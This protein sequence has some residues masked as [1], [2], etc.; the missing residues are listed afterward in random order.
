[1]KNLKVL[2]ITLS[3]ALMASMLG[4]CQKE[5]EIAVTREAP[6][7]AAESTTE[8]TTETTVASSAEESTK[9]SS[10]ESTS[11][12]S[13]TAPVKP[14]YK[15]MTNQ[16][17]DAEGNVRW[18]IEKEYDDHGNEIRNTSYDEKGKVDSV[19]EF[20]YDDKGNMVKEAYFDKDGKVT[21]YAEYVYEFDDKGHV[22][23]KNCAD[24]K[25]VVTE[26]TEYKY[27]EAGNEIQMM[28]FDG[29]GKFSWGTKSKYDSDRR[30]IEVTKHA[31][32]NSILSRTTYEYDAQGNPTK[33]TVYTPTGDIEW[34]SETEYSAAGKQA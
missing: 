25:A 5:E 31:D 21:A 18:T 9:T 10:E 11:E 19:A 14:A 34:W 27:D 3:L 24:E 7:S 20:K 23:K 17:Y 1:M 22:L 4:A 29:E 28:N 8:K 12:T 33:T 2:S 13:D 26:Y 16:S 32:N 15:T 30:L 6:T